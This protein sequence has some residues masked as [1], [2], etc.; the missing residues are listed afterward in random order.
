MV[1]V[2]PGRAVWAPLM[3]PGVVGPGWWARGG[4]PGVV[5][6]ELVDAELVDV[7]PGVVGPELVDVDPEPGPVDVDPGTGGVGTGPV[8]PPTDPGLLMP[9]PDPD[10]EKRTSRALRAR[11]A[12]MIVTRGWWWWREPATRLP[13]ASILPRGFWGVWGV[14][15]PTSSPLLCSTR[16][17]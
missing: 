4:G 14:R 15:S 6:L 12:T 7:D 1:G 17:E 16:G 8:M 9:P 13:A 2:G 10:P 11:Q 3:A 5:D